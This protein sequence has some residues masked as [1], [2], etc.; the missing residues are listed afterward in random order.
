MTAA[1]QGLFPTW[2]LIWF[3]APLPENFHALKFLRL[4]KSPN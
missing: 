1:G 4:T 3:E 2:I